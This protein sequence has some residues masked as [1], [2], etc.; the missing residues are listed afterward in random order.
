MNFDLNVQRVVQGPSESHSPAWTL[1]RRYIS[2]QKFVSPRARQNVR[3]S[4]SL[5]RAGWR[6][7]LCSEC[8]FGGELSWLQLR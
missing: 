2:S 7:R 3:D 4:L 5:L 8:K 6:C 1:S